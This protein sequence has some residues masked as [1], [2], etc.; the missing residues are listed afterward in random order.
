MHKGNF[1]ACTVKKV[2]QKK[3]KR[4]PPQ[5]DEPEI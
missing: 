1:L 5:T 3:K 2:F 4:R